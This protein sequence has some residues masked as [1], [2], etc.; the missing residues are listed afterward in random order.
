MQVIQAE[1]VAAAIRRVGR[2]MTEQ[3]PSAITAPAMAPLA[4]R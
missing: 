1:Q 2:S 4:R 3:R